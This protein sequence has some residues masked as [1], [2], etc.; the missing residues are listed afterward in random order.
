MICAH[1]NMRLRDS[2]LMYDKW[3]ESPN[4]NAQFKIQHID[5]V[6]QYIMTV[7]NIYNYV[8]IV[9]NS[10]TKECWGE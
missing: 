8:D 2:L 4:R 5:S 1:K 10:N 6:I 7:D 9:K 3:S